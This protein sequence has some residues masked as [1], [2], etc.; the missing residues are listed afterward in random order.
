MAM[1]TAN[2][3]TFQLFR[4]LHSKCLSHRSLLLLALLPSIVHAT[5]GFLCRVVGRV[6]F[7]FKPAYYFYRQRVFM[8]PV[9]K[10]VACEYK[11]IHG[12]RL[13]I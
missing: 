1:N 7:G 5:P 9:G 6:H 10:T 2:R 12:H 3:N 13:S 8:A 4:S 11:T